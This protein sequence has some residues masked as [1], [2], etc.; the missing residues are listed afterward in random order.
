MCRRLTCAVH[1]VRLLAS[2]IHRTGFLHRPYIAQAS[3]I[4]HTLDRLALWRVTGRLPRPTLANRRPAPL[5]PPPVKPTRPLRA[6][7]VA[8]FHK[9]VSNNVLGFRD[10]DDDRIDEREFFAEAVLERHAAVCAPVPSGAPGQG[11]A[12]AT[13]GA[14]PG[15]GPAMWMY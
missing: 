13:R 15:C 10:V 1:P 6:D 8:G 5:C 4:G 11:M 2:A 7:M 12:A 3:C 9:L 14:G